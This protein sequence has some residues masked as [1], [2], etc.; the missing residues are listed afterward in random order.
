MES[1]H[2]LIFWW[3]ST[4]SGRTAKNTWNTSRSSKFLFH[5]TTKEGLEKLKLSGKSG[6][7]ARILLKFVTR[8]LKNM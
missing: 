8:V 1:L 2:L 4:E 6:K 7:W 5:E 3:K